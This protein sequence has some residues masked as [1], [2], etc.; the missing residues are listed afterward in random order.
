MVSFFSEFL[1]SI[2]AGVCVSAVL[3]DSTIFLF[4]HSKPPTHF[5]RHLSSI[6]TLYT[7]L[8]EFYFLL[9]TATPYLLEFYHKRLLLPC[10]ILGWAGKM[11]KRKNDIG[12]GSKRVKC[13]FIDLL[14]LLQFVIVYCG[15]F[16]PISAPM[17]SFIRIR[18]TVCFF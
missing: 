7:F 5:L 8:L 14:M 10:P 17:Q 2:P 1:D 11:V 15:V 12:V 3:T 18:Y 9:I 4:R 13:D 16:G 6:S